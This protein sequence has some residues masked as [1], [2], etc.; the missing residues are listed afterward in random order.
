MTWSSQK[1]EFLSEITSF[2]PLK[3]E[4]ANYLFPVQRVLCTFHDPIESISFKFFAK[5]MKRSIFCY[6]SCISFN[7]TSH[8]KITFL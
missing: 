2:L 3:L 1:D 8:L 6:S 7:P 5:I 4:H